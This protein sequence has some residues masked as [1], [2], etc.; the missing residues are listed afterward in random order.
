MCCDLWASS[1]ILQNSLG[2]QTISQ[3]RKGKIRQSKTK[4]TAKDP[5]DQ[6][7][8]LAARPAHLAHPPN[9]PGRS[10][11][12]PVPP[13]RVG[14]G[15]RPRRTPLAGVEEGI[16][17]PAPPPP[18]AP[19]HSPTSPCPPLSHSPPYPP[20][21]KR[22]CLRPPAPTAATAAPNPL[23]RVPELHGR[24]DR[25]PRP[26]AGAGS[27]SIAESAFFFLLGRCRPR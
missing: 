15:A 17:S 13:T 5:L 10:L 9:R 26:R 16:R 1:H 6:T 23:Q 2:A 7:A 24:Q 18:L 12:F 27:P 22:P 3:N 19:P 21:A 11:P 25:H 20:S 4:R 14:T 8:Q